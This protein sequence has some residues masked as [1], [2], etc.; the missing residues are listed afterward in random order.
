LGGFSA[1]GGVATK[2]RLLELE[3]AEA[4]WQMPLV[5]RLPPAVEGG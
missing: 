5:P 4:A 2:Q 1:R 3:R